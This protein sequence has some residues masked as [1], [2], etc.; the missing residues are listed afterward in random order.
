MLTASEKGNARLGM[1]RLR[2]WG[3]KKVKGAR[4]E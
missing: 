1:E 3:L 2:R 4:G